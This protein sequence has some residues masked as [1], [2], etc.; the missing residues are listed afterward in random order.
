MRCLWDEQRQIDR[1]VERLKDKRDQP[2]ATRVRQVL[3]R[4]STL[5][6]AWK[7]AFALLCHHH[8]LATLIDID[9]EGFICRRG[10]HLFG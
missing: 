4:F 9:Q 5:R 3:K 7:D 10:Q 8:K 6:K 1:R 2:K